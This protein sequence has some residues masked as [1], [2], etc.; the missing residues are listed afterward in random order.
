[1]PDI[2]VYSY[3]D[4]RKKA[5]DFL[6]K[7]HPSG[8][9]PVPIEEIVEFDF[10]INIVPVLGLQRE[11]E[12]EGF[13]SGDLK[14]IYVDEYV[15]TDR[16][17]RYRFTLAH[18]IGHIVLHRHLYSA[19][20]FKSIDGW[21]EFINSLTEKEHSWLEYQGYAFAGLVLVPGEKLVKSTVEW[22]RK[23]RD[24]GISLEKNWDF[25]WELITE[26]VAKAFQVSPDVIEKR[27][28]KDELKKK[29]MK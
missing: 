2:P 10:G 25:A 5:D 14:N 8:D 1:M 13:T 21:K 26:H 23:I 3:E 24:K 20:K 22:T 18:E 17:T 19:H 16:I 27:M 29:Y 15:Y 11:F 9:I 12:V 4:L 28:E 6:H 7:H